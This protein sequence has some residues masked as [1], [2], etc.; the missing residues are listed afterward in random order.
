MILS[1]L[2]VDAIAWNP[3]PDDLV[4]LAAERHDLDI[5]ET[6]LATLPAK[7]RGQV[8]IVVDE[9]S[10]ITELA[11][12]GRFCVTWLRRDRGQQLQPAVDAWLGE[13][14]PVEFEREH[15]VY[16]WMSGDRTAQLRTNA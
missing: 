2:L 3:G 5:V 9:E 13:M 12:P 7:A 15:R 6:A 8:F 14:L 1:E 16:A 4:L 11:A 10:D